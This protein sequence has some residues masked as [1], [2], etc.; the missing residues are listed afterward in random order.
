MILIENYKYMYLPINLNNIQNNQRKDNLKILNQ[1]ID[2]NKIYKRSMF[3]KGSGSL[4][5]KKSGEIIINTEIKSDYIL[6]SPLSS[7]RGPGLI[8]PNKNI[9]INQIN[10]FA[11]VNKINTQLSYYLQE[12]DCKYYHFN[13]RERCSYL[14]GMCKNLNMSGEITKEHM[15]N[16]NIFLATIQ[17]GVTQHTAVTEILNQTDESI[18]FSYYIITTK[19]TEVN[20]GGDNK[21]KPLYLCKDLI[22]GKSFYTI[23]VIFIDR[24]PKTDFNN[25]FEC[26]D[27]NNFKDG[28]DRR[29][30]FVDSIRELE[31]N[32]KI[33]FKEIHIR[34]D[35][36]DKPIVDIDFN[37]LFKNKSENNL[38]TALNDSIPFSNN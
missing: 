3:T 14:N 15:L 1:K 9:T 2:L 4:V 22:A 26:K 38:L 34:N 21:F 17:R 10:N 12:G 20:F 31:K 29:R 11:H 19:P 37:K 6:K 35:F 36:F 32:K 13:L 25:I 18:T 5:L 7:P 16:Y 33:E 24:L 30:N 8:I 28:Y 23:P 27:L